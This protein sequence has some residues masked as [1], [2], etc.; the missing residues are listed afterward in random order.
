[1]H[2]CVYVCMDVCMHVC[3]YVRIHVCVYVCLYVCVHICCAMGMCETH[4]CV[5]MQP[6]VW[7]WQ[8]RSPLLHVRSCVNLGWV[9]TW[10]ALFLLYSYPSCVFCAVG[11]GSFGFSVCLT[12]ENGVA[13]LRCCVCGLRTYIS[14]PGSNRVRTLSSGVCGLFLHV[15]TFLLI[16]Q[17]LSI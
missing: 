17:T 14:I 11:F 13:L 3:V 15:S 4:V 2:V 6:C 1:M 7:S 12:C 10:H 5:E 8:C 16:K 9:D